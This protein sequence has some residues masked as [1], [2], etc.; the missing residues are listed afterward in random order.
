M[1]ARALRPSEVIARQRQVIKEQEDIIELL[2][3]VLAASGEA[4]VPTFQP[5]MNGLTGQERALMGALYG[6]YPNPIGVYELL[7]LMPGHDHVQ[8]RQAGLVSVKVHHLR[9]KLGPHAIESVR[10]TGYRMGKTFH[11]ALKRADAAHRPLA[12]EPRGWTGIYQG[13]AA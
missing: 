2:K 8:E 4:A 5:W 1:Y 11:D 12:P 7:E 6:R 13:R 3:G 10:G 9:K